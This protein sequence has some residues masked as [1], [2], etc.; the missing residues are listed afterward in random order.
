M[1][2]I[3]KLI[4]KIKSNPKD[5]TFEEVETL[6]K[7]FSYRRKDKGKTSGSRVRFVNRFGHKIDMHK[8]H[9]GN[10]LKDYQIKQIRTTLER[11]GLI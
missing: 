8:P 1:S 9:P 11:E 2:Q 6:L 3:K 7:F 4:D 5:M 10:I